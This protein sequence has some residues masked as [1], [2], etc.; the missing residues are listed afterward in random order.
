MAVYLRTASSV[1]RLTIMLET[2]HPNHAQH[3]HQCDSIV[4]QDTY[5]SV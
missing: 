1:L 4:E 5:L 2:L 3:T